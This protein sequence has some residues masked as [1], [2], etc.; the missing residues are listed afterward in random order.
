M[1]NSCIA[2]VVLSAIS[3]PE[4]TEARTARPA[5]AAVCAG[6][7]GLAP[8]GESATVVACVDTA[9]RVAAVQLNCQDNVAD[10]L[11][12]SARL[13][14]DAGRRGARLVVLPENFA[15]L[16][17]EIGKRELAERLDDERA[18]IQAALAGMAREARVTLIAGGFPETQR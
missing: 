14:A 13:V 1:P 4:R 7:A 12:A 6:G 2:P 5:L 10:N 17:P 16:G 8:P 18:P 3:V 15:Y 11:A 9:I